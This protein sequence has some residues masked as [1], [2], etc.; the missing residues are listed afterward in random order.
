[1]P[2]PTIAAKQNVVLELEPATYWW[3]ACGRS[4][5][6]PFCDSS[7]KGSEFRPIKF[8]LTEKTKLA[9]CQCK[10]SGSKPR[11]DGTHRTL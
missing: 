3:C 9:L 8:E 7:H 10:H 11:C 1:M 2:E 4:A 5:K 6:Q